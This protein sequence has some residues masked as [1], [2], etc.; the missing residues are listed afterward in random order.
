MPDMLDHHASET[1]KAF[2][3]GDQGKGK[4]GALIAL[5]AMGYKI[6]I[7]DFDNG[8]DI[9]K[10]LLTSYDYPYRKFMEDNNIPLKGAIH[11]FL[12]QEKMVKHITEDRYVPIKAEAWKRMVR[13]LEGTD[14]ESKE[15]GFGP[16]DSWGTDTILVYDTFSTCAE[17]AFFQ[18]QEL[19]NR[20]GDRFDEH[21]RDTGGAQNLLRDMIKKL[22]MA[23]IKCNV[24]FNSH[25]TF[26]DLSSGVAARPRQPNYNSSIQLDSIS[27]PRGYPMAVGRALSPVVGKYFNNVLMIDEEGTGASKRNKIFTVPMKGVSVKNSNFSTLKSSYPIETGLAE[28]FCALKGQAIPQKFIDACTKKK[29]TTS[30]S[31]STKTSPRSTS[32]TLE[33]VTGQ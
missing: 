6:R 7:L 19:N 8:A 17:C 3:V 14:K 11:T 22:F 5:A 16:V 27:D 32:M 29:S 25:I 26:V 9:L 13:I 24:L 4:T 15:Q 21:G 2:C 20:L 18:Q 10:N 31:S 12:L 33:Q 1:I 23:E 28:I 30:T